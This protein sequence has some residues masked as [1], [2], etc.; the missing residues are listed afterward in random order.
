MVR[1]KREDNPIPG[2]KPGYLP[3]Y[4]D[5]EGTPITVTPSTPYPTKDNEVV[6]ELKALNQ[7]NQMALTAYDTAKNTQEQLNKIVI[8]GDSSVEAAQARVDK[9]GNSYTTLKER[10]DTEH[11]QT[12]AQLAQTA[13]KEEFVETQSDVSLLNKYTGATNRKTFLRPSTLRFLSGKNAIKTNGWNFKRATTINHPQIP[14][15]QLGMNE[16]AFI[17]VLPKEN[18]N[19]MEHASPWSGFVPVTHNGVWYARRDKSLYKS[20]DR[21]VNWSNAYSFTNP[22]TG[23]VHVTD[24]GSILVCEAGDGST[25]GGKIY[26]STDGGVTFTMV[27]ELSVGAEV[28]WVG[29]NSQSNK[30]YASDYGKTISSPKAYRSLDDG[31]TWEVIY[32]SGGEVRH[33]HFA[34]EDP[35]TGHVYI[36]CGD[37][38]AEPRL[39]RSK[40]GDGTDLETIGSGTQ[41]WRLT[42]VEFDENYVYFGGD[43]WIDENQQEGR[44]TG[45]LYG[46]FRLHRS[47]DTWEIVKGDFDSPLY[48]LEWDVVGN[49]WFT[50]SPNVHPV[51]T[52]EFSELWIMDKQNNFYKIAEVPMIYGRMGGLQKIAVDNEL[53]VL[54]G[55]GMTWQGLRKVNIFDA[56]YTGTQVSSGEQLYADLPS[57]STS[58]GA[59]AITFIVQQDNNFYNDGAKHYLGEFKGGGNNYVQVYMQNGNIIIYRVENGTIATTPV[60]T[61]I[62]S[63]GDLLTVG[64]TFNE[65]GVFAGHIEKGNMKSGASSVVKT[66]IELS[67]FYAGG[68][69]GGNNA[70]MAVVECRVWNNAIS[71]LE[72]ENQMY[73]M[74]KLRIDSVDKFLP[75]Q[76]TDISAVIQRNRV[77]KHFSG[78]SIDISLYDEVQLRSTSPVSITELTGGYDGKEINLIAYNG[79]TTIVWDNSKIRLR[80]YADVTLQADDMIT[81]VKSNGVW[82]QKSRNF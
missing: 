50:T 69:S 11:E 4:I 51:A 42:D 49:L 37:V 66:P 43:G 41:E 46:L 26:R 73:D 64:V 80:P 52:P 48:D 63:K 21:G 20:T 9:E 79:N 78:S 14:N 5:E 22:L 60:T 28:R 61:P 31:A 40:I 58:G 23:G 32:D 1:L 53:M 56:Y 8:E 54:D 72:L 7:N 30:V 10:L 55:Y 62:F 74:H 34:K 6:A 70:G 27:L 18:M 16:P 12:T 76:V 39:L 57:P 44:V 45:M 3:Q 75:E 65:N 24:A 25:V 71:L 81:L 68:D 35:Y 2:E 36:A 77:L 17:A 29:L 33:I 19:V 59:F 82:Y 15:L 38:D 13:K 67:R 47:D